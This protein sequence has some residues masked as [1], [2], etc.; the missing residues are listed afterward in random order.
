M[1]RSEYNTRRRAYILYIYYIYIYIFIYAYY[2]YYICIYIYMYAHCTYGVGCT[3][4][5]PEI[6]PTPPHHTPLH[7][8][9]TTNLQISTLKTTINHQ[10][11][12]FRPGFSQTSKFQ[13]GVRQLVV[14]TFLFVQASLRRPFQLL[15]INYSSI[16]IH[17]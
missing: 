12:P 4:C 11:I 7:S 14:E 6:H 1:L 17:Q 13:L 10:N 16:I 8:T 5:I 2:I 15:I 3:H 9:P